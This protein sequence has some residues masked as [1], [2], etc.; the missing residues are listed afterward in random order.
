MAFDKFRHDCRPASY[1][2]TRGCVDVWTYLESAA[3]MEA[4]VDCLTVA[5]LVASAN[6]KTPMF[7]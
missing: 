1:E 5:D 7:T 3:R 4:H 2:W 6:P